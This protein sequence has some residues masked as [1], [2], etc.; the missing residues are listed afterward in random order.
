MKAK[1]NGK[2]LSFN[3]AGCGPAVILIRDPQ[4]RTESLEKQVQALASAGFRVVVPELDSADESP[5]LQGG[6][7]TDQM[8]E[9]IVEL[10]SYLGIGRAV[11]AWVGLGRHSLHTLRERYPRRI[12]GVFSD[13]AQ[14]FSNSL[15]DYLTGLNGVRSHLHLLNPA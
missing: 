15:G 5:D 14:F 9:T 11:I 13:S 7:V 12:A 1:I 10:M 3:D 6:T 8:A 4:A 2:E